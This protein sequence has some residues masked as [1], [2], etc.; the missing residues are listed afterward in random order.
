M[1][2]KEE[3][4]LRAMLNAL[5]ER[6]CYIIDDIKIKRIKNSVEVLIGKRYLGDIS[7]AKFKDYVT[8]IAEADSILF[9]VEIPEPAM[10]EKEVM[11]EFKDYKTDSTSQRMDAIKKY[12]EALFFNDTSMNYE[13]FHKEFN[14]AITIITTSKMLKGRKRLFKIAYNELMKKNPELNGFDILR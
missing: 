1:K 7:N 5:D 8:K 6:D 2:V 11:V 14:D 13:S 9:K 10:I 4:K 3:D 12:I